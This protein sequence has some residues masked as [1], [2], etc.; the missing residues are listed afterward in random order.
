[1]LNQQVGCSIWASEEYKGDFRSYEEYSEGLELNK[2]R[3]N[4]SFTDVLIE[5]LFHHYIR[6][7]WNMKIILNYFSKYW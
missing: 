4:K 5:K 6:E 3:F 7:I 2:S 1:M